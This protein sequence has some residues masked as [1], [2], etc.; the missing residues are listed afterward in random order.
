[1][2][3]VIAVLNQKGGVGKTT[4][5]T[6]IAK[7]LQADGSKVLLVDSDP[8]GSAS[9]WSAITEGDVL[10][11]VGLSRKSLA[12]DIQN[13]K[14]D[15]DFIVIDGAPSLA[16]MAIAAIKIADLVIIPVTPSP[17]DVWAA[18]DLVERVKTRQE[19]TDGQPQAVFVISRAIKN[20]GLS[21]EITEVLEGYD[22][23]VLKNVTTQRV[24]YP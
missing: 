13:V 16:E 12:K 15:Y 19:L 7:S 9:D 2:S 10:T 24:I 17:Y 6:H 21:K 22:L 20:T 23:P 11:V 18:N 8:Q 4:I 14:A 5:A 1:M 3:K